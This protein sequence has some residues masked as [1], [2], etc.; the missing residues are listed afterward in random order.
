VAFV[1]VNDFL[2]DGERRLD[3]IAVA[4]AVGALV[5]AGARLAVVAEVPFGSSV[6]RGTVARTV[7]ALGDVALAGVWRGRTSSTARSCRGSPPS[8]S[9][10]SALSHTLSLSSPHAVPAS[11]NESPGQPPF[12]SQYSGTSHSPASARQIVFVSSWR[13]S[14]EPFASHV[15]ALSHHARAR[16]AARSAFVLEL[17]GGASAFAVAV[18]RDVAVTGVR[19]QI[20]VFGSKLSR[21]PPLPSHVS[22]SSQTVSDWSPHGL[23]AGSNASAGQ[24]PSPSQY[25]ATSQSPASARHTGALPL[26]VVEA[27]PLPSHVSGSSQTLSPRVSPH[28][29]PLGSNAS[30]GQFPLP[31]QRSATSHSPASGRQIV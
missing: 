6:I 10:V 4:L 23:S 15:S 13:G 31:S 14:H 29:V 27:L 11:S 20:A 2:D 28:D 8:P 1:V 9:H 30:A 5:G 17:V 3:R 22:G 12:P 21:Q 24:F 19:R 26:E 7:A 18:F 16:V 25:S